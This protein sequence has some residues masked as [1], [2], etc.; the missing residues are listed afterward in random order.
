MN[1]PATTLPCALLPLLIGCG[2]HTIELADDDNYSFTTSMGGDVVAIE[3]C[4]DE[5]TIDWAGLSVDLQGHAVDAV[6]DVD[7]V[8]VVRFANY[9]PTEVLERIAANDLPQSEI[10]GTVE[11]EPTGGETSAP[12]SAFDFQGTAIDPA[13]EVCEGLGTFLV[14]AMT[15]LYEY[16]MLV[17]MAP[18]EG[19]T[20]TTVELTSST[21]TLEFDPDLESSTTI[22]GPRAKDYLVDW[23]GLSRDGQGSPSFSLSNIDGL[24]L[25]RYDL[26]IPEIEDQFFDLETIATDIYQADVGGLGSYTL[27][28]LGTD[29][30]AEF[31]GFEG[32]GYWILALRCSTCANPAPLFLGL[33]D[34]S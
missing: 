9:T 19:E 28:E 22:E 32:E 11:Y 13:T 10:S 16:R 31:Q 17:F 20:T 33:I 25:A 15:G 6:A 27:S 8:R 34:P 2:T 23:M 18:T 21:A 7:L 1:S 14:T 30:G 5:V 3:S 12:L 29:G 26:S 24:M 4:P